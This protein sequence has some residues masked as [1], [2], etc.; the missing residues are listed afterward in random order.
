MEPSIE[1]VQELAEYI[2]FMAQQLGA[3]NY[4]L[5]KSYSEVS[6]Q[7]LNIIGIVGRAEAIIMREIAERAQL[8]ISSIT[9]IIDKLEEKKLVRRIRDKEDRRIVRAEL[10]AKGENVYHLEME[11]YRGLSHAVLSALNDKEQTQFL[12]LFR[13]VKGTFTAIQ[14]EAEKV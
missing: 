5:N 12:A 14:A 3:L 8:A 4:N 11:G 7:E 6:K 9:P 2:D 13:K 1:G 10:T